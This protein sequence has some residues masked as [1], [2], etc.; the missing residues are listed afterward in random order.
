MKDSHLPEP[1]FAEGIPTPALTWDSEAFW[2]ACSQHRLLVQ[3]CAACGV[4]RFPPRAVCWNCQ[5]FASEWS[6]STGHGR[7]FTYTIAHHTPH[8]AAQESA[9]YN[10]AIVQLDDCDKVLVIS[11]I[12]ECPDEDLWVGLPVRLSWE[13]RG[14]GRSVYRFRPRS[15]QSS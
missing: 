15:G 13:D 9:P 5:S 7:V 8:P 6:E 4:H 11:N 2:Q 14:D 10:I 3:R 12:V 1:Y